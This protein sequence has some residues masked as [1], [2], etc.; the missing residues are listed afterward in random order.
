[1]FEFD[2]KNLKQE[3]SSIG[4]CENFSFSVKNELRP[5][6]RRGHFFPWIFSS[7]VHKDERFCNCRS[8][9]QRNIDN[10]HSLLKL[11]K[12]QIS[13][14]LSKLNLEDCEL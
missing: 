12:F 2:F 10:E 8:R 5:E 9:Q 7:F 3:T 11:M 13:M 4:F 6:I 14:D 1:M